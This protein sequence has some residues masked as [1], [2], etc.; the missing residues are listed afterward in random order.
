MIFAGDKVK[1]NK[2]QQIGTVTGAFPAIIY[3]GVGVMLFAVEWTDKIG[4]VP[5]ALR[6]EKGSHEGYAGYR[7]E[8]LTKIS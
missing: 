6:S 2:T 4:G 5:L 3:R 8:E 1:H 7:I